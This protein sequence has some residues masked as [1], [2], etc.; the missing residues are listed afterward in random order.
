VSR[1]VIVTGTFL[2]LLACEPGVRSYCALDGKHSDAAAAFIQECV[3]GANVPHETN[4]YAV[5]QCR[6]VAAS[7]WCAMHWEWSAPSIN[8]AR[9]Y[10]CATATGDAL[11]ACKRKGYR[12]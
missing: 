11:A 6:N 4:D 8:G 10:P 1:I 5:A 12:P 9:W 2:A 7:M 3:A